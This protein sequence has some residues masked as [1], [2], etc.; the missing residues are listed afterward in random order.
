MMSDKNTVFNQNNRTSNSIKTS[1]WGTIKSS[2]D[3][4]LGFVYRT[5]FIK[6]LGAEY[7]GLNGLF[8]NILQVLSLAELGIT[9][10]IVYRFYEPIS[11]NNV[12][13][14]GKLMNYLKTVYRYIAIII[15]VVGL[16]ITPF[17]KWFIKDT[18]SIP[19]DINVY[20]IYLLFLLNTV[21]SYL[22]VYK[23][24]IL[25]AD[26]R[27][28]LLSI[29]GVFSTITKYLFQVVILIL[30]KNYTITLLIGIIFTIALNIVISCYAKIKYKEVFDE[31]EKLDIDSRREI[32]SDTK[33]VMLHRIGATVKLSTDSIILSKFVSLVSTGIYSNYSMIITGV[34]T[35]ISQVL[36]SF[37]SSVGNAHV[38]LSKEKNFEI[39]KKLL[40]IDLWISAVTVSCMY[41][42]LNDFII[43]WAGRK[44]LF[45]KF[46]LIML[47]IQFY[48]IISRQI[49][50][51][52]TNGCG[53]F[54]R[55]KYRPLVEAL[56]NL[57]LSIIG[58]K[59]WGIVGVFIGTVVS[60][61]LTICWR[62]PNILFKEEFDKP[63]KLYW[64]PYLSFT[65]CV[66]FFCALGDFIK[67]KIQPINTIV[68]LFVEAVIC[69]FLINFVLVCLF[70]RK[71][72]YNNMKGLI[73]KVIKKKIKKE[74]TEKK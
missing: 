35:L 30:T 74:N 4:I 49:N 47:C 42:L 8:T 11:N 14:V 27:G 29:T 67:S 28:Y 2:L 65:I 51:S 1:F 10:A 31:K 38:E 43:L 7:L 70:R 53:L 16:I 50:I 57:V 40:F 60:S 52:Y 18:N 73:I 66:F 72:E 56:I 19:A 36:G 58:V 71:N 64:Q 37:V 25:S 48:I 12:S 61:V 34:Q 62:E 59:M 33:A 46:T 24:T 6:T 69:F 55:D 23:Q 39:Y 13:R 22:F 5:I 3:I 20:L 45:D 9:T 68:M 44:Y 26:Q 63:L 54:N 21:S 41:L 15:F 17:I 32:I